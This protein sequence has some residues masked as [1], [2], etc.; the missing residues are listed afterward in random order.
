MQ[1]LHDER[2]NALLER[3]AADNANELTKVEAAVNA[4]NAAF[5]RGAGTATT[6]AAAASAVKDGTSTIPKR[7]EFGCDVNLQKCLETK[8]QA[9]AHDHQLK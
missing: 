7:D 2:A 6:T 8:Q 1:R 9:Q 3:H 4:A 5:A